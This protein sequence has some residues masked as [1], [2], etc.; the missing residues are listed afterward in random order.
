MLKRSCK[1]GSLWDSIVK[2]SPFVS[3]MVR[4]KLRLPTSSK[5]QRKMLFAFSVENFMVYIINIQK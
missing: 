4:V 1:D 2:L 3:P 5:L